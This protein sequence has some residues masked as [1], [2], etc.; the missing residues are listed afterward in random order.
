[1]NRRKRLALPGSLVALALCGCAGQRL[2]GGGPEHFRCDQDRG[3]S[4]A[5]DRGTAGVV[6]DIRGMRFS[7]NP[8]GSDAAGER[9]GCGVLTLW[10]QGDGARVEV[11]GEPAYENCRRVR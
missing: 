9:L 6:I 2:P 7:L 3:F 5:R 11:Q 4:L 1:M 10:R 8:E